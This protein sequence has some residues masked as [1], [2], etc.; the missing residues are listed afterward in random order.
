M[1]KLPKPGQLPHS[2]RRQQRRFELRYP[3]R[4][5]IQ[6][7]DSPAEIETV[8]RNAAVG[9]L[10]LSSAV[11]IPQHT[12]VGFVMTI[13]EE[14][15][16]RPIHLASDG[17]VVRV[18]SEASGAGFAIAVKCAHPISELENGPLSSSR[19]VEA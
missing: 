19:F 6:F 7:A 17:K 1:A 10:L 5:W 13:Q 15:A 3:V 4:L 16:L 18:E 8:S 11:M 12:A 9:G 14:Q 2:E